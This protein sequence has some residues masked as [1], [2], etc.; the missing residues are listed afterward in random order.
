MKPSC[1]GWATVLPPR[2]LQRPAL[3]GIEFVD[4]GGVGQVDGLFGLGAGQHFEQFGVEVGHRCA[5]GAKN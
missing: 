2:V 4:Q 3:G 1:S 5:P